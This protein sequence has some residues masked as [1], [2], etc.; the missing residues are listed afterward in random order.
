MKILIFVILTGS[1]N[2][3]LFSANIDK[4][5]VYILKDKAL[6]EAT[7]ATTTKAGDLILFAND[8]PNFI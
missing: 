6:L 8:A 5:K 3:H 7:L 2:T 4:E 1:L